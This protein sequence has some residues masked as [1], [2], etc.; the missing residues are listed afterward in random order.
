[1]LSLVL[2]SQW[3]VRWL[4]LASMWFLPIL[5]KLLLH[6]HFTSFHRHLSLIFIHLAFISAVILDHFSLHIS[7]SSVPRMHIFINL[8]LSPVVGLRLSFL[9]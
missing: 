4:L 5:I 8:L 7:L 9:R 1:M 6:L 2:V 3:I